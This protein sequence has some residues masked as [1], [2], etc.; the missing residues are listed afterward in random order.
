MGGVPHVVLAPDKFRGS[1]TAADVAAAMARAAVR[2]GWTV[3]QAPVSDGG[4]GFCAALGGR[5]RSARVR[6]PLGRPVDAAW[7]EL[8]GGAAASVEMARASGL[9]LAGGS[10]GNDPV[11]ADTVG[12]G[13]LV[14][15]AIKAGARQV[16]IGMGGSATTDGGWGAVE[17]L[18]PHSRLSGI[19]LVVACDVR[20]RFFD[21]A[22]TFSPQKGASPAQVQFL[23]RRLERLAQVY[24]ERFGVDVQSL[25]G[26]GAAGGLAGGLAALGATLVSGFELVA[27]RI[28]LAGRIEGADLVITGEG[29][30]DAESFNGKAVGGVVALARELDVP[31]VVLAGNA[32]GDQPVQ[33]RTLVAT[34][35]DQRAWAE[36]LAAVEEVVAGIIAAS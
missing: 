4:E 10:R 15:A 30:L 11:G 27:D 24:L 33:V 16:L 1:A 36:P 3:D 17:A 14:A 29:L 9:E 2:L 5:A 34:V 31:V 12:T 8:D 20:T 25:E 18:E 26:S 23:T 21:A 6:D 7:F 13:Q 35:G 32:E 28:D 19:D 22:A